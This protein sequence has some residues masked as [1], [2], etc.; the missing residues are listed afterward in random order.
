MSG[1]GCC[2]AVAVGG[3]AAVPRRSL[4]AD[5]AVKVDKVFWARY[6]LSLDRRLLARGGGARSRTQETPAIKFTNRPS[7]QATRSAFAA[8]RLR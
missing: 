8:Q 4:D 1:A 7:R 5:F 3:D 2:V 6:R